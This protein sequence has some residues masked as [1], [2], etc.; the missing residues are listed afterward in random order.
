MLEKELCRL[1]EP[2][3]YVQI[4]HIAD[5]IGLSAY[6]VEKKLAQMILDKKFCGKP[7]TPILLV[8]QV[9]GSLHQDN[10]ILDVYEDV[11]DDNTY[12]LA[13]QTIHAVGEVTNSFDQCRTRPISGS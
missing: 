6:Q 10:G 1:I 7:S 3:S 2:Y 5:I 8:I 11:V 9:I 13:I 4:S 12:P